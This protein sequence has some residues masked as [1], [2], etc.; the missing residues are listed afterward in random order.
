MKLAAIYVENLQGIERNTVLVRSKD[1]A[2]CLVK[3]AEA[4]VAF[5]EKHDKQDK[6]KTTYRIGIIDDLYSP[7]PNIKIYRTEAMPDPSDPRD[8]PFEEELNLLTY[9]EIWN[10]VAKKRKRPTPSTF[11]RGAANPWSKR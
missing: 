10:V 1:P 2:A 9:N 3:V 8:S 6:F 5:Y 4:I 11:T 7:H